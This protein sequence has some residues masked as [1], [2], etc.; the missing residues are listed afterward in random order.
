MIVKNTIARYLIVLVACCLQTLYAQIGPKA[1][2]H[3][4]KNESGEH[5][6]L[7]LTDE[8]YLV[9]TVYST[10][11]NSFLK[12][13]GGFYTMQNDT[14]HVALEFNSEYKNDTLKVLKIPYEKKGNTLFLDFGEG[15]VPMVSPSD[16]PQELDGKWLMA[17]RVSEEGENRRDTTAPRKTMK[18]LVNGHFQWIA[19]NTDTMEFFGTGGGKFTSKDGSYVE[20]IHY[21][22]RDNSRVGQELKFD[23]ELKGDDWYHNGKSSQGKPLHEIWARRE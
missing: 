10:S 8:N 6:H 12:T 5:T 2:S 16:H 15:S 1:H 14:L 7:F 3:T 9:Y 21:F 4:T 20:L 13:L 19:F 17:G 18:F 11:P 23:Y 22:P